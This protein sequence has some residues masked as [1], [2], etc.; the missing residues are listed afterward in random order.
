MM[1]YVS[2]HLLGSQ[3]NIYLAQAAFYDLCG[4]IFWGSRSVVKYKI[5]C[6]LRDGGFIDS[7]LLW[8][9]VKIKEQLASLPE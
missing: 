3:Q 2:S 9:L 8:L 1:Y 7:F 6:S 4:M 5:E